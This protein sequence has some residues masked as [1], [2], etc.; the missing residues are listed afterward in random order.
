[1]SAENE[2]IMKEYCPFLKVTDMQIQKHRD[3]NAKYKKI[4]KM[5]MDRIQTQ[6]IQLDKLR[7]ELDE[8]NKVEKVTPSRLQQNSSQYPLLVESILYSYDYD[9]P[10]SYT[11]IY[12]ASLKGRF[13]RWRRFTSYIAL[14]NMPG[15]NPVNLL[16]FQHTHCQKSNQK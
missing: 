4:L 15:K 2:L 11:E 14:Y 7:D 3:A 1:M 16:S 10:T 12:R 6:E 8:R 9:I 13:R 5:A